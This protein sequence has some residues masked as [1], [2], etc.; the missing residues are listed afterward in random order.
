M[1]RIG[2]SSAWAFAQESVFVRW[3]VAPLLA[4]STLAFLLGLLIL[5]AAVVAEVVLYYAL[6]SASVMFV[7]LSAEWLLRRYL[8]SDEERAYY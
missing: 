7:G 8:E 1:T 5:P 4:L 2:L 6:G 3:L